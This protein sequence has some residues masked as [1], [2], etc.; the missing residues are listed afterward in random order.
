MATPRGPMPRRGGGPLTDA[1]AAPL[2]RLVLWLNARRLTLALEAPR[3]PLLAVLRAHGLPY[4]LRFRPWRDPALRGAPLLTAV[5]E[6]TGPLEI[7]VN[8]ALAAGA[9]TELV[10]HAGDEVVIGQPWYLRQRFA[11]FR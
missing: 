9:V 1:L 2:G 8:G 11:F 5:A 7:V 6:L 10:V 4:T 3:M